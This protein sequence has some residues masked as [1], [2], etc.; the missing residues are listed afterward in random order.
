MQPQSK[1]LVSCPSDELLLNYRRGELSGEQHQAI[2]SHLLFCDTCLEYLKLLSPESS[3]DFSSDTG[4]QVDTNQRAS[5]AYSLAD[6]VDRFRSL[7]HHRLVKPRLREVFQREGGKFQVG[8]IWRPKSHDIVLPGADGGVFSVTDLDSRPH[9]VVITD[10]TVQ[11]EE[12]DGAEYQ[13]IRVAPI[14]ADLDCI[15]DDDLVIREVDSPLGYP[16]LIQIWNDQIMLAENLECLLAEFHETE[17]RSILQRLWAVG[18]GDGGEGAFSL[19]AVIM[20]GLYSDPTMRYRAREYEDT[21]YLRLPVEYLRAALNR[22]VVEEGSLAPPPIGATY[23]ANIIKSVGLSATVWSGGW[24]P[25]AARAADSDRGSQ[26]FHNTDQSLSATLS[27]VG[28][29]M[30]LRVESNDRKWDGALVPFLWKSN[31]DDLDEYSCVFTILSKDEDTG[32]S[33]AEVKLGDLGEITHRG[34]PETPF[35]LASLKEE[36]SGAIRDSIVRAFS[37]HELDAWRK[38]LEQQ[39]LDPALRALIKKEL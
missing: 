20:K 3:S 12:L 23:I 32:A 2:S 11:V 22:D 39:E 14:D 27:P 35:A 25:D 19:E 1:R 26:Q 15:Q 28:K 10:A 21:S 7:R 24:K 8:Q 16:F 36:M 17:H 6:T 34:L 29:R 33:Y 18:A 37:N 4:S 9:L 5:F 13:I 30:L 31:V 38:L